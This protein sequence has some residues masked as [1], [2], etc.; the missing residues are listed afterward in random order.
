MTPTP[1]LVVGHLGFRGGVIALMLTVG[2]VLGLVLSGLHTTQRESQRA[3][4][5]ATQVLVCLGVIDGLEWRAIAGEDPV[6]LR[7]RLDAEMATLEASLDAPDLVDGPLSASGHEYLRAVNDLFTALE[8]GEREEA[9]AIDERRVDPSFEEAIEFALDLAEREA[10]RA[11][12]AA[13]SESLL[14]LMASLGAGGLLAMALWFLLRGQEQRSAAKQTT[15]LDRRSRSLV[16]SSRDVFTVVSGDGDIEVLSDDLG[17]IASMSASPT[18]SNVADL[19]PDDQLRIW[20]SADDRLR[21]GEGAQR[22]ELRL[23]R[24]DRTVVYVEAQGSTLAGDTVDRVWVWRDISERKELELQLVHQAF[25]D[26]LT[27]VANR[28]LLQDRADHALSRSAR[29]GKPVSVLFCDLDD[30]KT[31]NDSLGHGKGDELLNI[32]A[33][34]LQG[35]VRNSDT[36]ARF[37]GDEFAILLEDA[38]SEISQALAERILD[39]VRYEVEL[40][41]RRIFPSV[42]IGVATSLPDTTT[43]E[44]L[45]N[46]DTAMYVAKRSGKDRV[47]V[48]RNGMHEASANLLELQAELRTALETDQLTLHYQPTVR[49]AD[50]AVEGVEALIRWQHPT[51]GLVSPDAF[52]PVAEATGTIIAIGRW[53]L[54]QACNTALDLQRAAGRPLMMH[55]NLSPLQLHDPTLVSTVKETLKASGLDPALLVLEVTEGTLL[56]DQSAIQRLHELKALGLKI[57]IDDF[58]T[59]YT[60]ISYLQQLPI[61]ILKIDRSFVSGDALPSDQR[62]AFLHAIVGLAKSLGVHSVAE[63]IERQDQLDELNNLGCESGQGF[64]WSPAVD[65]AHIEPTIR[66]INPRATLVS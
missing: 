55:V 4:R 65:Q 58:G 9:E 25:H 19:L 17:V 50:A 42:S 12:D 43:E 10:D 52:I 11:Q 59:G 21:S 30:F 48:F 57:A 37:G 35:C 34:R 60:S 38:G 41:G 5:E 8:A 18:S 47:E 32:M 23:L 7:E 29:T 33:T 6:E 45:R 13:R 22:V 1:R 66:A 16:R 3:E 14:T 2:L 56:D 15:E 31:V 54:R 49:L 39:V 26:S 53:V 51:K 44:L 28:A 64:L 63:G 40:D 24:D 61:D 27:G 36:L 20:A 62:A 46:A